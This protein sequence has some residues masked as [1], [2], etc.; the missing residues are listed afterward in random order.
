M[1]D[2]TLLQAAL[3]AIGLAM[4]VVG[5]RVAS[6]YYEQYPKQMKVAF[7]IACLGGWGGAAVMGVGL[8]LE[9]KK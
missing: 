6:A 4:G 7:A 9:T 2:I 1:N 5:W 8:Y 3:Y